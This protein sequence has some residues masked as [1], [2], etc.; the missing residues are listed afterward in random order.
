MAVGDRKRGIALFVLVNAIFFAGLAFDGYLYVPPF[1][2]RTPGFNIV[3]TLT[4]IVQACNG[5]L[6]AL[7]LAA[8]DTKLPLLGLLARDPGTAWADL[9]AVHFLVSGGLNYF[10]TVRLYDL[11]TG[12]AQEETAPVAG[13]PAPAPETAE[14]GAQP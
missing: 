9:G 4:F 6:C 2:P 1:L 14:S 8:A 11:L 13:G 3:A 10:A 12:S 7:V 5:G